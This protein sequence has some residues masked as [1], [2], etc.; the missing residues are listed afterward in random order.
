MKF[1]LKFWQKILIVAMIFGA[2]AGISKAVFPASDLGLFYLPGIAALVGG[3]VLLFMRLLKNRKI[4]ELSPEV[5]DADIAWDE[6]LRWMQ[7]N[8][9]DMVLQLGFYPDKIDFGA[10]FH[11][12]QKNVGD[13]STPMVVGK[14]K[15][16]NGKELWAGAVRKWAKSSKRVVPSVIPARRGEDDS[17]DSGKA[18]PPYVEDL[19]NGMAERPETMI[20]IRR[21][22][23][24]TPD[25]EVTM[26]ISKKE[27]ELEK[28]KG[29]EVADI[30]EAAKEK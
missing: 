5:I 3:F 15:D 17:Y 2:L 14:I 22:P 1:K 8:G 7:G 24:G 16:T 19:L 6:I 29:S 30:Y 10:G 11:F 27:L 12:Q 9:R 25:T 4:Q 20:E 26:K 18:L 21:K 23:A 13:S 28:V